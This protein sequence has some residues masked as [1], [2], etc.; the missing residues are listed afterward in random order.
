MGTCNELRCRRNSSSIVRKNIKIK[1]TQKDVN[2][3]ISIPFMLNKNVYNF[4]Y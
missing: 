2:I 4:A 3:H 1:I